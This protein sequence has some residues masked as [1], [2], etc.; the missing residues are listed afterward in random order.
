MST[1]GP[2]DRGG[3][4]FDDGETATSRRLWPVLVLDVAPV[5][6][7]GMLTLAA[8]GS[9]DEWTFPPVVLPL[10]V[11]RVWPLA[12][13]VVVAAGAVVSTVQSSEPWIPVAAVALASFTFGDRASDRT[14]SAVTILAVAV[15]MSLGF[16][17]ADAEPAEAAV[18]TFVIVIPSWL[19]GDIAR[20]RREEARIR[21]EALERSLRER[22]ERLREAAAEERRHVARELHDVVAH[23]VSVMVIQAGAA[24]QVL[25]SEPDKAEEALLAVEST[26]RDAM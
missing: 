1:P 16:T 21:A 5:V 15:L 2:D 7:L 6:V 20:T 14:T 11:R 24:R 25:R 9:L 8:E 26:G 17:A 4:L 19:V 18:L 10:L 23:A 13:L 12:V 22:E 3:A